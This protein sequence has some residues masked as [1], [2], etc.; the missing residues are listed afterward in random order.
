MTTLRELA[1]KTNESIQF[2]CKE[3]SRG[4]YVQVDVPGDIKDEFKANKKENMDF[5]NRLSELIAEA[6]QEEENE[7]Y[8]EQAVKKGGLLNAIKDRKGGQNAV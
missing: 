4:S 2:T 1:Q 7:K 8:K 3:D 5:F 6:D